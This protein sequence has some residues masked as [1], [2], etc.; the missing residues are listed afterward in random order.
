ML[1]I[2]D[3]MKILYQYF[4]VIVCSSLTCLSS[5]FKGQII[6]IDTSKTSAKST[7]QSG[8]KTKHIEVKAAK[9]YKL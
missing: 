4:K 6:L 5:T 2:K 1:I 8:M 9:V 7:I 3:K